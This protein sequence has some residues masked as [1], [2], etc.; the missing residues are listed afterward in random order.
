MSSSEKINL[1]QID[2][3]TL[4]YLAD[5]N[6][7]SQEKDKLAEPLSKTELNFY[8]KR[9]INLVKE[10]TRQIIKNDKTQ[11]K[12]VL[13]DL[14]LKLSIEAIKHFKHEDYHDLQ[15]EDLAGIDISGLNQIESLPVNQENYNE[16]LYAKPDEKPNTLDGF[17]N[18][19]SIKLKE[20][21]VNYPKIDK[22]NLK[23]NNL[24]YKGIKKKQGKKDGK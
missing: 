13:D 20:K 17:V 5:Y 15:Q 11:K 23:D 22:H 1:N 24:K 16:I 18:I 14:I 4:N 21:P 10:R 6:L 2:A 12:D 9:L 7:S 8:R 3:L 19:K